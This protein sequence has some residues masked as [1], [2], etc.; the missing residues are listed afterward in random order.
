ME[1]RKYVF[2]DVPKIIQTLNKKAPIAWSSADSLQSPWPF[3]ISSLCGKHFP[4]GSR[5]I[6]VLGLLCLKT[7]WRTTLLWETRNCLS[8]TGE[9]TSLTRDGQGVEALSSSSPSSP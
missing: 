2:A 6:H 1:T 5:C 3:Y 8:C 7:F 9:S 4:E